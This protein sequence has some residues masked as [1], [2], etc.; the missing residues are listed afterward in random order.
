MPFIDLQSRLGINLDQWLLAQSG[1]QPQ[2]RVAR[3]HAFEKEWI[4]CAHGIGQTRAKRECKLE[5]E[6][7]YECMHRR[8]TQQR[9][10]EVRKQKEKMIKEGTYTPPPQH[11]GN[12]EARP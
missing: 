4:E 7:F 1:E 9:L 3:C 8:K 2:K 12:E 5:L 11:T 10:Y 6:D